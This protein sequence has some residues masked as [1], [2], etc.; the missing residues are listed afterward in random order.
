LEP[1][2][3][4]SYE[5]PAS[6]NLEALRALIPLYAGKVGVFSSILSTTQNPPLSISMTS[7]NIASGHP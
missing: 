3:D 1:V 6:E 4:S 5:D 2:A 7:W